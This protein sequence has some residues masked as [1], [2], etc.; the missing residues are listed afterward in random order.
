MMNGDSGATKP[1]AVLGAAAALTA[2]LLPAS[3]VLMRWVGFELGGIQP[4]FDSAIAASGLQLALTGFAALATWPVVIGLAVQ[5]GGLWLFGLVLK[6]SLTWGDFQR[7]R[8]KN[9]QAFWFAFFIIPLF[10]LISA[11]STGAEGMGFAIAFAGTYAAGFVARW[12]LSDHGRVTLAGAI[13][14]VVVASGFAAA[15]AAVAGDVPGITPVEV[16]FEQASGLQDGVFVVIGNDSLMYLWSCARNRLVE[17][18]SA[19]VIDVVPT[20]HSD[21]PERARFALGVDPA[22]PAV[23]TD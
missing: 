7:L 9:P 14:A 20:A 17:V 18:N 2:A 5:V 10:G 23:S 1:L 11:A 13:L 16:Q 4:S 15:G 12:A 6:E 19:V 3:G 22:C 8:R 21:L